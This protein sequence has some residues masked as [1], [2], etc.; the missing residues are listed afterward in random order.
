VV[1]PNVVGLMGRGGR[2]AYQT[3]K[4]VIQ[5]ASSTFYSDV[6]S[7]FSDGADD[8]LGSPIAE[9]GYADN[10]WGANQ[11]LQVATHY[12]PTAIAV[13]G[14]HILRVSATLEDPDEAHIGNFRLVSDDIDTPAT[15]EQVTDHAIWMGL[16]VE[17]PGDEVANDADGLLTR[18]S[19]SVLEDDTGL[20]L[21]N[22]PKSAMAPDVTSEWNGGLGTGGGYCW[23]VGKNGTVYGVYTEGDD[24]WYV[25]FAGAYP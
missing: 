4:E 10:G 9:A 12:Y 8:L 13:M 17:A 18:G 2:Q 19:V 22:I 20:Y 25:G 16:L 15:D 14:N 5:L 7:G 24:I 1:I 21:Q 23:V 3:D 6:H 11:T